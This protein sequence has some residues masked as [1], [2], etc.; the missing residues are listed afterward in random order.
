M[1]CLFP[2]EMPIYERA[3]IPATY[4]GHPLADELP[5]E[6]DRQAV[7]ERLELPSDAAVVAM[8]PGSRQS[9][10]LNLAYAFISAAEIIARRRP[11]TLFLVPLAT[12]ETRKIFTDAVGHRKS[13]EELP[14]RILFGHSVDAMIAADVVLVASGTACLE[15]ALLKR[16]MVICY[17]M[18]KWQF[19]LVRRMAY[20]PWVGL[21][22]I[23][24]NELVVPELLQDAATPVAIA[25][26]VEK[27]LRDPESRERLADRFTALH[28]ELR[29]GTAE[30]A[31]KVILPYL[32][33]AA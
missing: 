32:N 23:L 19:R 17:R 33:D 3:G 5:M 8:L 14:L 22:N 9:E 27:W 30:R 12:R 21:P 20:L 2:F 7:R 1:L 26:A 4:V 24:L 11:G 29:R 25:D 31:S 18:G 13:S 6:P 16:P 10:V 28:Q 15:A